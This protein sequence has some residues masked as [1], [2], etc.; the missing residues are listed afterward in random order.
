MGLEFQRFQTHLRLQKPEDSLGVCFRIFDG[1]ST[2]EQRHFLQE[3]GR[4]LGFLGDLKIA[5][6]IDRWSTLEE[7]QNHWVTGVDFENLHRSHGKVALAVAGGLGAHD[8][9]H[10]GRMSEFRARDNGGTRHVSIRDGNSHD[11]RPVQIFE[12]LGQRLEFFLVKFPASC[13]QILVVLAVFQFDAVLRNVFEP[14]A[15]KASNL[16]NHVF[17]HRI[18]EIQ[19]LNALFG[20][21]F[22]ELGSFHGIDAITSHKV[23][24]LLPVLH[25]FDVSFKALQFTVRFAGFETQQLEEFVSIR[26]VVDDTHLELDTKLSIPFIVFVAFGCRFLLRR[27]VILALC[28]LG[29]GFFLEIL[30]HFQCLSDYLLFDN[31]DNLGFL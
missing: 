13:G 16:L 30:E 18:H 10:V 24:F 8:A 7:I 20:K 2:I 22:E 19:D 4:V 1:V 15:V 21:L 14:L 6:G 27:F 9:F 28:C 11:G 23:N 17:V 12:P 3:H 31:L 5:L 29:V 26:F 25:V